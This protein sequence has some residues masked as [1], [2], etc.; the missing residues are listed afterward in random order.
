MKKIVDDD[1]CFLCKVCSNI[2]P[3]CSISFEMNNSLFEYPVIDSE[4]C[5]NCNLC[6]KKCISLNNSVEFRKPRQSYIVQAIS[7]KVL[8]KSSSGGAFAVISKKI[9]E[10]GGIVFG[11]TVDNS[12]NVYHTYI[13]DVND[14]YKLQGS[15]YVQSDVLNSY[16]KVK[17]FLCSGKTVLFSGLPC[18]VFGLYSFLGKDYDNLITID[19]V[20]HGTLSN[21]F[22]KDY[23]NYY[24]KRNDCKVVDFL[25]RNKKFGWGKN[26]SIFIKKNGK[27]KEKLCNI[28]NSSYY[29]FFSKGFF[30]KNTCYSCPFAQYDRVSDITVGDFWGINDYK[31]K[32]KYKSKNGVS[33]VLVNSHKG[34]RTFSDSNNNFT[35]EAVSKEMAIKDNGQLMHPCKF[36]NSCK[37]IFNDYVNSKDYAIIEKEFRRRNKYTIK[38]YF[39]FKVIHYLKKAIK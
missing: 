7:D 15:K 35:F 37:K 3:K 23:I 8:N 26:G 16:L 19:L 12:F 18:Q 9:L 1:N 34:E 28:Y 2:C 11:A 29:Y 20:C 24:E 38:K 32:N 10:N 13:D 6:S 27:I 39:N 31:F 36:D 4:K 5:I 30:Y 21:A 33:L 22:L 17:K 14:L 25:F